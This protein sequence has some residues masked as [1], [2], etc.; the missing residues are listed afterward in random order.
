MGQITP[1]LRST[2]HGF[3]WWC[4]ACEEVHPL[5][6]GWTF[7]G[8][9][10]KPTFSPSF[11]HSGKQIVKIDGKWNGEWVCDESGRAVDWCCH[12][13]VTNGQVAYCGDCT[14]AMA[15]KTIEMPDLPP[16]LRDET[17]GD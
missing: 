9:L 5:P 6:S 10:D 15:G 2:T 16:H 3:A 17:R 4:P 12:Y 11:R 1:K 8:D 7:N 14:H 13:V